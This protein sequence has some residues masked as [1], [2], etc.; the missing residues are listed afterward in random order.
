MDVGW[1]RIVVTRFVENLVC[2]QGWWLPSVKTLV[3]SNTYS[4][5][6]LPTLRFISHSAYLATLFHSGMYRYGTKHPSTFRPTQFQLG[7]LSVGWKCGRWNMNACPVIPTCSTTHQQLST[8][9][10]GHKR[11]CYVLNI[12]EHHWKLWCMSD[13]FHHVPSKFL[14]WTKHPLMFEVLLYGCGRKAFH[15]KGCE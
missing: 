11:T 6:P 1:F 7:R 9:G 2:A 5:H 13:K 3:I 8:S 4:P 12:T 15:P 10:L 14:C